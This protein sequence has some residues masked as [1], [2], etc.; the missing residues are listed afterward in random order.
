M[1][2]LKGTSATSRPVWMRNSTLFAATF[3]AVLLAL[4]WCMLLSSRSVWLFFPLAGLAALLLGSAYALNA[5]FQSGRLL[6]FGS[7]YVQVRSLDEWTSYQYGTAFEES[8]PEQ[9]NEA[10]THY[11]V[12]LRLFPARPQDMAP[13]QSSWQWLLSLLT[14]CAFITLSEAVHGWY[15]FLLLFAY[16]AWIFGC[17]RLSRRFIDTPATSGL[18]ELHLQQ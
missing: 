7:K 8:S 13:K 1:R 2:M 17:M 16:Y 5:R 6:G 18:T 15:R 10:L 9:Q 12:G 11:R 3:G 14:F 4:A